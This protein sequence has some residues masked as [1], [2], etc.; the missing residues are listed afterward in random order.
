MPGTFN[1]ACSTYF[2]GYYQ[3]LYTQS[4]DEEFEE[5]F[6]I[7][8]AI[9]LLRQARGEKFLSERKIG[10]WCFP[11]EVTK[12]DDRKMILR[13]WIPEEGDAEFLEPSHADTEI[14][15]VLDPE[16]LDFVYPYVRCV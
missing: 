3:G 11:C 1:K 2:G 8:K 7:G 6:T 14:P 12:V 4:S 13:Q 16:I 15:I 9:A 10:E 5:R